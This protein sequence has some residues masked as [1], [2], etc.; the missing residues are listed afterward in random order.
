VRIRAAIL[1]CLATLHWSACSKSDTSPTPVSMM[2]IAQQPPAGS[3]IVVPVGTPPGAF[4]TRGTNQFPVTVTFSSGAKQP[5][6]RLNVYLMT[7][8]IT[9]GQNLPDSPTWSPF[10]AGQSVTYTVTGFQIFSLPCNVTAIRAVLQTRT[11]LH[12]NLPPTASEIVA[13]ATVA[14]TYRLV[15][16]Q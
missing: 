15:G 3:T 12:N 9:C 5:F 1:L 14:T 6:A 2:T 11:D 10:E 8:D 13:D 4:F 16:L 7:G